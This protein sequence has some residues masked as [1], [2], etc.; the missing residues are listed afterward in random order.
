MNAPD[1]IQPG[2]AA[3]GDRAPR[4]DQHGRCLPRADTQAACHSR[5]RRYFLPAQP[6]MDYAAIHRRI[7]G[8]LDGAAPDAAEFERLARGVLA[9]L[10]ADPATRNLLNGVHVPFFLPQA[11]HDDI[12][13]ALESRYLPAL[14][15]VYV[16]ALP[17]YGFVNHHKAGLSGMLTPADGSRHRDLIA[18]MARG[19]VVGVYFP[20]LLEYSLPAALEQMADLPGHFLL[21]GGYDTAAA[22]IGSPDLLLRKDGY[23]PLMWL[24]G[25]DSEKEGVGYHFEAYGYDLTFNRRVHQGMAAEYWASGLVVLAQ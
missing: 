3:A 6:K 10:E 16:E 24:S 7:A 9:G 20:C 8:Q 12:G 15:R 21:A 22:F 13:E 17:E 2:S 25:L 1:M 18:A 14:E 19:P 4:F 5:T 11:S 23:P